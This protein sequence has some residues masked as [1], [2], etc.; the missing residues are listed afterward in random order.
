LLGILLASRGLYIGDVFA[1]IG[2]GL[3]LIYLSI[4]LAYTTSME[5]SDAIP[6][7]I[8]RKIEGEIRSINGVL[9]CK[10]LKVRKVGPTIFVEATVTV[11][12][13]FDFGE[14]HSIASRIEASISK[15]VK[16]SE[17]VV[18]VEPKSQGIPPEALV[19]KLAMDIKDVKDVHN[20]NVTYANG[21]LYVILHAQVDPDISLEGAHIIAEQIEKSITNQIKDVNNVTVHIESFTTEF[22]EGQLLFDKKV[23]DAIIKIVKS[24]P[25]VNR[26]NKLMTYISGGR[27]YINI[28]CCF[29]RTTSIVLVH[30]IVSDIEKEI[31]EAFND[32]IVTI[33]SEPG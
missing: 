22:S 11:P 4:K 24:H 26:V 28:H 10:D 14:S 12:E 6:S 7:S 32:A 5:L 20:I 2:L 18:H 30:N 21:K 19:K 3:L 16:K 33:H 29:D 25:T 9:E 17:V 31:K 8:V 27:R 15:F 1:S 23:F 13:F